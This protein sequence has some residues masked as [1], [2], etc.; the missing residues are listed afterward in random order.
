[1][2]I[3]GHA[4]TFPN[5]VLILSEDLS[6]K[7]IASE[8]TNIDKK[9]IRKYLAMWL[10]GINAHKLIRK[11]HSVLFAFND[12]MMFLPHLLSFFLL[13]YVITFGLICVINT[14]AFIDCDFS[15]VSFYSCTCT[16]HPSFSLPLFF[17]LSP[18]PLF[19]FLAELETFLCAVTFR[20]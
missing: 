6:R 12:F 15:L 3:S 4:G 20:F 13:F 17:C 18:P 5:S 19:I 1:M 9:R 8:R 11:M 2:Q 14:F 7:I 16:P 10:D